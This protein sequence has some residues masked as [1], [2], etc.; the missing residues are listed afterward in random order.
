MDD[1]GIK[2]RFR[3]STFQARLTRE[4]ALSR[5]VGAPTESGSTGPRVA[6]SHARAHPVDD[7]CQA[8]RLLHAAEAGR[9]VEPDPVQPDR[10]LPAC[11]RDGLRGDAAHPGALQLPRAPHF[12]LGPPVRGGGALP[13]SLAR[14]AEQRLE[15]LTLTLSLCR[16]CPQSTSSSYPAPPALPQP[17]PGAQPRP[18]RQPRSWSRRR[19]LQWTVA[20]A[21]SW[22]RRRAHSS[23]TRRRQGRPQRPDAPHTASLRGTAL[24]TDAP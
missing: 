23:Q 20:T 5:S 10:L 4:Q 3:A 12:L 8:V 19:S 2:R 15:L 13:C 16:S 14:R 24:Q 18:R 6:L 21:V 1:K 9:G 11:V 22:R 7:A 17:H